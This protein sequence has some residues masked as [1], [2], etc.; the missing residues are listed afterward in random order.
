MP[1]ETHRI[2][3]NFRHTY[4]ALLT[5]SWCYGSCWPHGAS[6]HVVLV[7]H[8]CDFRMPLVWF[9]YDRLPA[10][11]HRLSGLS[12]K[13]SQHIVCILA[14]SYPPIYHHRPSKQLDAIEEEPPSA[15]V[16]MNANNGSSAITLSWPTMLMLIVYGLLLALHWTFTALAVLH[17]LER[18]FLSIFFLE[19]LINLKEVLYL[20][21]RNCSPITLDVM[22][23]RD[24]RSLLQIA[25]LA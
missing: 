11:S 21:I 12:K 2:T 6:T 4:D 15:E 20:C 1:T 16:V 7:C 9:P 18:M 17:S 25:A 22:H 24:A 23:A 13:R 8:S 3:S 10:Y 19:F 14:E 5:L